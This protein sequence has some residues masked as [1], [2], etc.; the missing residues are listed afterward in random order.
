MKHESKAK[1]E[2][3]TA[4]LDGIPVDENPYSCHAGME[5]GK[6]YDWS[7]GWWSEKNDELMYIK[8]LDIRGRC[9]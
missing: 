7:D 6:P 8:E 5:R 3:R 4:Y 2:G 1:Q 9:N